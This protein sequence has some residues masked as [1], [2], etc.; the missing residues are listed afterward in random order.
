ME[1]LNFT[2]LTNEELMNIEAGGPGEAAYV[3]SYASGLV[4]MITNPGLAVAVYAGSKLF[5]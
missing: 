2:T 4:M 3:L 5:K 1:N